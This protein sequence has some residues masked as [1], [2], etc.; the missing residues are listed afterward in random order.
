[1]GNIQEVVKLS[2]GIE[3]I[4]NHPETIVE[5]LELE[6][7][8]EFFDNIKR[9]YEKQERRRKRERIEKNPFLRLAAMCGIML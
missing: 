6:E 2:S 4:I 7:R 3:V 1:M 8:K 9:S 5:E